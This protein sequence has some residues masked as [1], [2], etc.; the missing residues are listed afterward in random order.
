MTLG[1]LMFFS[2]GLK[3]IISRKATWNNDGGKTENFT[4]RSAVLP[5]SL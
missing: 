3:D 1:G 5:S 2:L 4:G